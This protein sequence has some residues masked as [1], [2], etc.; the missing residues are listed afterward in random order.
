MGG[1]IPGYIPGYIYIQVG[2]LDVSNG[3]TAIPP[4]LRLQALELLQ[5]TQVARTKA[6]QQLGK[7][8]KKKRPDRRKDRLGYPEIKRKFVI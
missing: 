5:V 8:E 2:V 7:H 1:Y 4:P 6:L 3:G